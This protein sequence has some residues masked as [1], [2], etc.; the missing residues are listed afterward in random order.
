[1]GEHVPMLLSMPPQ[2]SVA[3]VVGFIKG[4]AAIHLA[5]TFMG[6]GKNS[7]G[8]HGWARGYD[9][10]PVGRDEAVSR[11]DIR[12]QG[13]ED[14]HLDHMERFTASIRCERFHL[15]QASG[16]AGGRWL[17]ISVSYA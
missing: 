17:I 14:R 10:S 16:F 6:R 9:G 7:P 15:F 8:H 11:A 5:R 12:P 4:K 13:A 2:Y 1:M 3:H